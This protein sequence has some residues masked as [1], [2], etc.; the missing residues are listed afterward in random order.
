MK[1]VACCLFIYVEGFISDAHEIA[2]QTNINL[3][4]ELPGREELGSELEK[5]TA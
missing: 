2:R 4:L 3:T 1:H 5:D